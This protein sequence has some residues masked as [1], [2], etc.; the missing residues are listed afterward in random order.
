VADPEGTEA[1]IY[2]AIARKVAI[3]VA[4]KAKDTSKLFPT[5]VVSRNT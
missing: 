3:K 1:Q 4:E 2:K 5:I